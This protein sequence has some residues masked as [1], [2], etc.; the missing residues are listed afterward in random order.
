VAEINY[1]VLKVCMFSKMNN[2]SVISENNLYTNFKI[3]PLRQV[4][5][6]IKEVEVI[7]DEK[8]YKRVTVRLNGLG[9][10]QR[11][12]EKGKNI[13]TKRQFLA[14]VGQL[15]ISKIDARN[16]A[17]GIIPLELD[18]AIVTSDF[19]L[20]NVIGAEA[21]Y[22]LLVLSSPRFQKYWQSKSSG[23]TNRQRVDENDLLSA[24][25]PM[26]SLAI[27]KEL[28]IEYDATLAE[29]KMNKSL[30]LDY[31]TKIEDYLFMELGITKIEMAHADST[32]LRTIRFKDVS[33]WG[34]E[35]LVTTFPFEVRKYEMV[36]FI[37]MPE[38]FKGLY[39]GKSP[40]YDTN[41]KKVVINQ[42]CNRWNALD[43]TFAK[44][45]SESWLS[46]VDEDLFT[47]KNDIL[48][49]S[50]GEGTIGRASIVINKSSCGLLYDSHV[51]LLRINEQYIHPL[52]FVYLFN[53]SFGQS[54]IAL[55]KGAQATKQTELGIDNIKKYKFPLPDL[56]VQEKIANNIT[57]IIS[58][59]KDHNQKFEYLRILAQ[60]K[61][62]EAVFGEA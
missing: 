56:E 18:A 26:P 20:Y 19:L 8:L 39:R 49:N 21:K 59:V 38:L 14:R 61:F 1:A 3:V 12:E 32:L 35:R 15:I 50:T 6:R 40:D 54:Q 42:K 25:V 4:L 9:I 55:L 43:L 11:D 24:D 48:I 17:F 52:Y 10:K 30:A 34:Y 41:G 46:S 33:F 7:Q 23:T 60:S 53:S 36:S 58:K 22:L 37:Q 2:W 27:Q 13:G 29:A 57:S 16:G 44:S 51:L 31:E 45:V 62:E 47:R 5:K 28:T